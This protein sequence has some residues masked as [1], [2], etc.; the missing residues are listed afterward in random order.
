MLV[1]RELGSA[2]VVL[3]WLAHT[4]GRSLAFVECCAAA[5]V[6]D[7]LGTGAKKFGHSSLKRKNVLSFYVSDCRN[8]V[9]FREFEKYITKK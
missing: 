1:N 3:H 7:L 8:Y 2:G 6:P 4:V 9:H 5:V